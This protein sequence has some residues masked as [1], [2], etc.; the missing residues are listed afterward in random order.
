MKKHNGIRPQDV[1]ILL[2]ICIL[3]GQHWFVKDVGFAL[4]ISQSE[5]SESLNRSFLAGLLASDKR[6]V[7]KGALL[8][9]IR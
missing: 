4:G 6:T 8:V 7:M 9:S 2:K 1:V 5:I 3:E